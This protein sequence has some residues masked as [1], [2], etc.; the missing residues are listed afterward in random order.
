LEKEE[1]VRELR[2]KEKYAS[3]II[4]PQAEISQADFHQFKKTAEELMGHPATSKGAKELSKELKEALKTE[5]DILSGYLQKKDIY[6]FLESL[7]EVIKQYRDISAKPASWF[8]SEFKEKSAVLLAQK[9]NLVDPIK[10]FMESPQADIYRGI[11]VFLKDNKPNLS[12]L[13][14]EAV[15][16]LQELMVDENVYSGGKLKDAKAKLGLLEDQLKHAFNSEKEKALAEIKPLYESLK[17]K[18][19]GKQDM[20]DKIEAVYQKVSSLITEETTIPIIS[21][22]KTQFVDHIYLELLNEIEAIQA[23]EGA[24]KPRFKIINAK[25]LKPL[26]SKEIIE[27]DADLDE[28][29]QSLKEVFLTELGKGNRIRV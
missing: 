1:L 20:L 2:Q 22:H 5:A 11:F 26:F 3:I 28:Y 6:H 18:S 27:S 24:N 10:R 13:D 19:G 12:C 29:L 21:S 17:A 14:Q 23:P 16:A 25:N 4:Q 9:H 15:K 7:E 8:F